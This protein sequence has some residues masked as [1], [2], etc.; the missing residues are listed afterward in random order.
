MSDNELIGMAIFV[1]VPSIAAGIWAW[2]DGNWWTALKVFVGMMALPIT[3]IGAI[4]HTLF[5]MLIVVGPFWLLFQILD[6]RFS[7]K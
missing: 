2:M 7:P 5:W 4:P 6:E 3:I 1:T